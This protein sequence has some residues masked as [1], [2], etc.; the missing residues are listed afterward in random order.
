[1]RTLQLCAIA[2]VK[3]LRQEPGQEGV[4][5]VVD[6][7]WAPDASIEYITTINVSDESTDEQ[8]LAE[9]RTICTI[10]C[11]GQLQWVAGNCPDL[12]ADIAAIYQTQIRELSV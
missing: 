7:G 1:M 12:V 5:L 9:V 6:Q 8:A 11:A 2:P 3:Y 10:H 4:A